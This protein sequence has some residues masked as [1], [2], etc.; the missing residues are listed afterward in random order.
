MPRAATV[1]PAAPQKVNVSVDMPPSQPGEPIE[2]E[3][4]SPMWFWD[5]LQQ[6]P[7]EQWGNVYSVMAWREEPK[8]PG[9]PGAKG[10]LFEAFEPIT[11][12][13]FKER[14]GGGKFKAVLQKNSK[15]QTTHIFDVEGQPKYD[16]SR[17]APHPHAAAANGD[18]NSGLLKDFVGVLRDELARSRESNSA[19]NPAT[20]E[21]ISLLSKASEKAM[22]IVA[23]RAN[24]GA[25]SSSTAQLSELVT[26][27]KG[28]LP[29]QPAQSDG[30]LMAL[31]APVIPELLKKLMTPADP[32][33]ELAKLKSVM[34]LLDGIRGGGGE[35][36]AKD[37]RGLLAE[38]VVQKAPEILKEVREIVQENRETAHE[39]RAAAEAIREVEQLRRGQPAA[40]GAP[41]AAAPS[42]VLTGADKTVMPQGPLRTVPLDR[43]PRQ[44]PITPEV[45]PSAAAPP[46]APGMAANESDA[47]ANFMMRRI[48]EMVND[49]RDAEDVVDFIEEVDPSMNDLLAQFSPEMVTTFLA[50]RPIIGE[51]TQHPKWNSFLVQ[52][53]RYIKE[54]REEDKAI[55]QAEARVPA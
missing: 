22:D 21:A 33:A 3:E 50:A 18:A 19:P 40:P 4:K 15:F 16:L 29:T 43:T 44:Q 10:F 38:G 45:M 30:G 9:V 1:A 41:T 13:Y 7:R 25:P 12:S 14:Y 55:A 48:V 26:I 46:A 34:E 31:L 52:A 8:V 2:K 36:K 28:L 32:L 53:Q 5:M 17:E 6:I 11:L 27:V 42:P 51:A 20:D 35:S 37:W 47:V 23:N 39:R 24:A 54:I 49:E